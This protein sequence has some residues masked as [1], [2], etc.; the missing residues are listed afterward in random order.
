LIGVAP[1]LVTVH[2]K[3]LPNQR[4]ALGLAPLHDLSTIHITAAIYL[5]RFVPVRLDRASAAL[6]D[7]SASAWIQE[8]SARSLNRR[9]RGP[10]H[11]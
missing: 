1:A 6:S 11:Y 2:G 10:A 8:S 3:A 9:S 4:L 5:T 7:V